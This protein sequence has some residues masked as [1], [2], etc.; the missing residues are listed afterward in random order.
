MPEIA[1][2]SRWKSGFAFFLTHKKNDLLR[3]ERAKKQKENLMI[4]EALV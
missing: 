2:F 3:V 1:T 4:E